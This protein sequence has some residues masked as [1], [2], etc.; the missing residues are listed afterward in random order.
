[1]LGQLSYCGAIA[2]AQS[3]WNRQNGYSDVAGTLEVVAYAYGKTAVE[4]GQNKGYSEADVIA[5]N[6]KN[7]DKVMD[8]IKNGFFF[9]GPSL[10]N[11]NENCL[12]LVKY[13]TGLAEIWRRQFN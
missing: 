9:D 7:N 8:E 10:H 4:Y 12:D 1:M 11:K 2:V 6:R 5:L 3:I 13:T